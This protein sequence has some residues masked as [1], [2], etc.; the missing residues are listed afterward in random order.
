[1]T[2]PDIKISPVT[3]P[4]LI[5]KLP[6]VAA[7]RIAVFREYPYL[8][9][10][11]QEYETRYLRT[12][13]DHLDSVIVLAMDGEKVIGASTA[14]PMRYETVEVREPF[15]ALGIDPNRVF[16]LGESVLLPEYRGQGIGKR[17]FEE[18]ERHAERLGGFD[19]YAFCAVERLPDDPRRPIDYRSLHAFWN[20]RGYHRDPR[21]YTH[22]SWREF[23][24]AQESPKS[25]VFW[26]KQLASENPDPDNSD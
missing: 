25:M 22:F 11:D 6:A 3:G 15:E 4:E 20:R 5:E 21:L 9:D 13:A 19:Y 8:Y 7:L 24:E 12:Y 23:G 18:R 10:G 17:F 26:L 16:Y 1:M 14:V 2:S